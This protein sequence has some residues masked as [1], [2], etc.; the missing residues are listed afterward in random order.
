MK[1]SKIL[2]YFFIIFL[3]F[4]STTNVYVSE[5]VKIK[6][7]D[8]VD[9]SV[10][11]TETSKATFN[12]LT[13]NFNIRFL[14]VDD[15][16]KY[17]IVVENKENKDY[18]ISVDSEFNSSKYITYEYEKTDSL[19]ANSESEFYVTVTYKNKVSDSDLISG[20][21]IENNSGILKLSDNNISN[22]NTSNNE[23]M[24]IIGLVVIMSVL[25]VLF[26]NNKNRK[27]NIFIIVGL[28]SLPLFVKAVGY[29]KITVKSNV[30]IEKGYYVGYEVYGFIKDSESDEYDLSH[31]DCYGTV[32]DGSVSDE[33]K[34]LY[35]ENVIYKGKKLYAS[36]QKVNF[37][38]DS[39]ILY[40]FDYDNCQGIYDDNNDVAPREV[41]R[42]MICGTPEK[43]NNHI[44]YQYDID[45]IK[46]FDYK[47][48]IDD[49][50]VMNFSNASDYWQDRGTIYVRNGSVFTMPNHNV[51]FT[52]GVS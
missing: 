35:C 43:V 28:L 27:L 7:I 20:K 42:Q 31:A 15:Y 26:G 11:A 14:S 6:S 5:N 19:K 44:S 46:Y 48:N 37:D 17:K 45:D 1:K 49:N 18:D 4:L 39:V 33:N 2:L 25:F 30:V 38:S 9:K 13:M 16:A 50:T 32:Y 22:P 10:N 52:E 21:Y 41:I 24:I 36:G 34:Y 29:L 8:L 40:D 3:M 47:Y 12:G 51:L 23:V